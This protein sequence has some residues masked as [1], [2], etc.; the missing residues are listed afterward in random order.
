MKVAYLDDTQWQFL[1]R[2]P[3]VLE[4]MVLNINNWLIC[5]YFMIYTYIYIDL[6]DNQPVTGILIEGPAGLTVGP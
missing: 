1:G 6:L 3:T 2:T 4:V 5:A